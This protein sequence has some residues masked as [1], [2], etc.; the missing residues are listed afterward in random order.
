ME[1]TETGRLA[2]DDA[3]IIRSCL[4]MSISIN[5]SISSGSLL[6]DIVNSDIVK[7]LYKTNS[8]SIASIRNFGL[9][10]DRL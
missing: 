3:L 6:D 1:L 8:S 9:E 7:K 10:D 2:P 4:P 5:I